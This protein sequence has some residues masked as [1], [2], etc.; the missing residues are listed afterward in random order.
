M[1][2]DLQLASLLRFLRMELCVATVC[3]GNFV[4][5]YDKRDHIKAS[6]YFW[7]PVPLTQFRL[8]PVV[9]PGDR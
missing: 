8:S 9:E 3:T 2:G 4:C 5:F 7:I 1:Y 6:L